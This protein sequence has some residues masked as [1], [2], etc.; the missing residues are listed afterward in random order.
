MTN[1]RPKAVKTAT[2]IAKLAFYHGL[3][4]KLTNS[5]AI[6]FVQAFVSQFGEPPRPVLTQA[7]GAIVDALALRLAMLQKARHHDVTN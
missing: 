1:F 2:N 3:M 4:G 5:K 7:Q 6:I